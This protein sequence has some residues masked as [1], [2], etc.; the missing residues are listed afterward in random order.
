LKDRLHHNDDPTG[1][2]MCRGF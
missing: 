1:N 2:V